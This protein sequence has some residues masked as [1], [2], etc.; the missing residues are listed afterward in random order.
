MSNYFEQY[1]KW[2]TYDKMTEKEL[3]QINDENEIED[4]FYT[5]LAFGTGGLRGVM[6]AG[7]NRLNQYTIK[8][9]SYGLGNYLMAKV[10]ENPK[11]AIAYDTRN[12]SR[13]FA[14]HAADVF[15][16]LGIKTVLF[17]ECMPTPV[18][19]FA[20]R[21]LGCDAGVV[22]TASHNPKEYNGYKVYNEQGGQM[23]PPEAKEVMKHI[24][25]LSGFDV[26]KDMQG[27]EDYLEQMGNQLL[28]SFIDQFPKTQKL[29]NNLK[30]VYSPLHGAG[31]KP[32]QKILEPFNVS[33]VK[34]Q[35]LP[36]GD[37][38]TVSSPNPENR[39][40]LQMAIS[41]AKNEKAHLVLATDPDCDRLGVAVRQQDEYITLT[42]NQ[43]GALMVDY[44]TTKSS[45]EKRN[46]IIKTIVTNEMGANIAK[47]RGFK[48]METL[49]GF[50][51]IGE[52]ISSFDEDEQDNAFLFGY[53]E[54][55]GFLFGTHSRDKDAVSAA[56]LFCEIAENLLEQGKT[57]IDRLE[58]I[59]QEFG[60]YLD[61]LDSVTLKGKEG[62]TKIAD[63]MEKTRSMGH[64]LI[65]NTIE[66]RDYLT[67]IENLPAEN[68]LKF[69][70]MDGSWIAIRPSG[71]EPKIK[72]YYS[73]RG[74]S[75]GAASLTLVDIK[76][77]LEEKLHIQLQ[78]TI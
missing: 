24:D 47:E 30:I 67:G 44:L 19:S 57:V 14:E 29:G 27:N 23:T 64:S 70:L 71:T 49:T 56:L 10:V 53:E 54:S 34:E 33:V 4:R 25:S 42:G 26:I 6:G 72:F 60:F 20:V 36:D 22:I 45:P 50:K 28:D 18:L 46:V 1:E 39:E 75:L 40:V 58:E 77:E 7:T 21:F 74:N 37:F 65:E 76:K 73:V 3:L 62:I 5:D 15:T 55:Y 43:I 2:L 61:D 41:Q 69:I 8:K 52:K 13:E 12:R 78:K 16:A 32:I 48:V 63:L 66:V 38:T 68:V 35:E 9:A 59:Y 17:D 31:N 11:I 51:Y